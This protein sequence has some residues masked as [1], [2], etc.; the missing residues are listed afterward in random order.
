MIS[1]SYGSY[2]SAARVVLLGHGADEQHAGYG[3]HRTSFRNQGWSGLQQELAIDMQRLWQR[4]LGRDDRLVADT[5]R[6]ARHPFLDEEYIH[7]VL[8]LP[9]WQ[10]ADLTQAPGVG[11]KRLLRAALQKLGLP[12]AAKRVKRA[13]QFGTGISKLSNVR[14]FG[15]NRAANTKNAGSL[16]LSS[17]T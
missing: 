10:I 5:S 13:I 14:D 15:S 16:A 1:T 9:L 3:R 8:H 6:E 7:T 4:N 2:R 11:D 12:R 17:V